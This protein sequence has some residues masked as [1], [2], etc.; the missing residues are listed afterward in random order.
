M[1]RALMINSDRP[2]RE[3]VALHL[4]DE[5]VIQLQDGRFSD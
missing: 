5:E 2:L 1:W 4:E 3:A